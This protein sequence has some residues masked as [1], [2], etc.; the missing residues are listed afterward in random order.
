MQKIFFHNQKMVSKDLEQAKMNCWLYKNRM[1]LIIIA[2]LIAGY[3][4]R[5]QE[6][7]MLIAV[8]TAVVLYIGIELYTSNNAMALLNMKSN[9][10]SRITDSTLS[11]PDP[12]NDIVVE[13]EQQKPTIDYV[14]ESKPSVVERNSYFPGSLYP[15][16]IHS[17]PYEENFIS[18]YKTNMNIPND[19]LVNLPVAE[20][21]RED[22]PFS[23]NLFDEAQKYEIAM[24]SPANFNNPQALSGGLKG[25]T[26]AYSPPVLSYGPIPIGQERNQE[27]RFM[28]GI[29]GGEGTK[30]QL[31]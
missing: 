21:Q 29:Q 10:S 12:M 20:L 11:L 3:I 1:L 6:N 23:P 30:F 18:N 15:G 22:A 31:Y 17:S 9:Y 28:M 26:V 13:P 24:N 4:T 8:M 14:F 16:Q 7:Y 25:Q 27:Q 19:N 5:K 2:A